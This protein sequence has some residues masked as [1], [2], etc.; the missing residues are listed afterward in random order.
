MLD[1]QMR[2]DEQRS[3]L[4]MQKLEMQGDIQIDAQ[5]LQAMI[6]ATRAQGAPTGV[7]WVDAISAL[8]RPV[9]TFW[10]CVVRLRQLQDR[11]ALSGAAIGLQLVE[12]GHRA[13]EA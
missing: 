8:V 7:P 3:K 6:E 11:H 13:V 4:E 12:R 10:Y 9:L 2:A 1:L 5:E